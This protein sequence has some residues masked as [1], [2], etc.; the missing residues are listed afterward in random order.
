MCYSWALKVI[1]VGMILILILNVTMPWVQ[2][3]PGCSFAWNWVSLLM[4]D[5]TTGHQSSAVPPHTESVTHDMDGS[6]HDDNRLDT[7]AT[8]QGTCVRITNAAHSVC[9]YEK[10]PHLP[11][12]R[13]V[14]VVMR[15]LDREDK[16]EKLLSA[17]A[18]GHKTSQPYY[19]ALKF[20]F[21]LVA[22]FPKNRKHKYS[23]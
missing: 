8:V 1:T 7:K 13:I 23:N 9:W 16:V 21:L 11:F 20:F 2:Q 6:N 19:G 22:L 17:K 12:N 15:S 10:K 18:F 3:G 4:N 14:A 5:Q